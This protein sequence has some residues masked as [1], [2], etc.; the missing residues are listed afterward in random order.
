MYMSERGG[1]VTLNLK[2]IK[3]FGMYNI[4]FFQREKAEG[5]DIYGGD[6]G[7]VSGKN[8]F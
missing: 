1:K 2:I 6:P 4:G 5:Y 8:I 3:K 7:R